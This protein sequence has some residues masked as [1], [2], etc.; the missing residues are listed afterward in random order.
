[1]ECALCDRLIDESTDSKE[2]LVL[3]AVG[4]RRTVR[5]VLCVTCNSSAGESWDAELARQLNP[6]SLLFGIRRGDGGSIPSEKVETSAGNAL[7]LHHDGSMSPAEPTYQEQRI[8]ERVVSVQI[9]ARTLREARRMLRGVKKKYPKV[10]LDELLKTVQM[11]SAYPNDAIKLSLSFGGEVAGR[12]LVKSVLCMAVANGVDPKVCKNAR[13]YLRSQD[14]QPGFGYYYARDLVADR[15]DAVPLHCIAVS[16]RAT[17]GQLLGYVEFFGARRVIVCLADR[18][19]GPDIHCSYAINPLSGQELRMDVDL[20]LSRQEI[21]AMYAYE[22]IPEGSIEAA[23]SQVLP[24]ALRISHE[25]ERNRVLSEAA[26]YAFKNCGAAEGD[27]MTAAHADTM[28]RLFLEKL[29]PYLRIRVASA[30][31]RRKELASEA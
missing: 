11:Q 10:E 18:Y 24:I 17:D 14:A 3:N 2:H 1:M 30:A 27:A 23:F 29:E 5:G 16:N 13:D 7:R 22:R 25:R 20:D 31:K 4:G 28:T 15:P 21:A 6:L 8:G 9:V 19:E 12:S 26:E